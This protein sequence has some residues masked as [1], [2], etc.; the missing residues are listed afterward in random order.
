MVKRIIKKIIIGITVAII[1]MSSSLTAFAY[2]N[3]PF[4]TNMVSGGPSWVSSQYI[5]KVDWDYAV[6]NV[7]SNLPS[8]GVYFRMRQATGANAGLLRHVS[9]YGYNY[10]S[11]YNGQGIPNSNY[12]LASSYDGSQT[13]TIAVSGKWEP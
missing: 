12:K 5:K 3:A 2:T 4:T 1:V 13:G 6:V 7:L 8:D 10:L 9:S 11:Y